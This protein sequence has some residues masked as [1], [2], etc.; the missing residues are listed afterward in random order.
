[1]LVWKESG[2]SKAAYQ[3]MVDAAVFIQH[4]NMDTFQRNSDANINFVN[5]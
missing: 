1:M 5:N 2:L 4:Q 3:L